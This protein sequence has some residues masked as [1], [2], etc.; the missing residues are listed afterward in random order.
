MNTL[1]EHDFKDA[2]K[3]NGRNAGNGAYTRKETTWRVMVDSRP[4]VSF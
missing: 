2:F 1:T 3:K 4:E